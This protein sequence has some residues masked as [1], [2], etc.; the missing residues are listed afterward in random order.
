MTKR[1]KKIQELAGKLKGLIFVGT[2]NLTSTAMG[3]IFWFFIAALM[4]TEEYGEI[5]YV[6][7]IGGIVGSLAL[8]GAPD[9]ITVFS[10]K[11][12]KPQGSYFFITIIAAI[13]SSIILLIFIQN[14]ELSLYVIGYV[15]FTL[16][17][18]DVLGKKKF[19]DYSKYLISQKIIFIVISVCLFYIIGPK[20]IIFGFALSFF[21]YFMRIYFGFKETKIETKIIKSH[22][23]FSLNNYA[24]DLAKAFS[25][26]VDKLIIGPLLGF[27]LLGNYALGIQVLMVFTLLP[28]IMF[29]YI[30]PNEAGGNPSKKMK[31]IAIL[32]AILIGFIGSIAVPSIL[33][34][35]LPKYS[36]ATDVIRIISF[37]VIPNTITLMYRSKFLSQNNSFPLMIAGIIYVIVQVAC[38][39]TLGMIY[40]VNGIASALLIA[41]ISQAIFLFIVDKKKKESLQPNL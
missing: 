2:G 26:H 41:A 34:S 10:A 16:A 36:E 7:S 23:R 8:I 28:S 30:L 31:K 12:E 24:G 22:M 14:I 32:V 1:F 37:A 6:L 19:K 20:G 40:D 33:S 3:A 4:S 25:G 29:T 9:T 18:A 13:V 17:I 39:F 5:S 38:I 21:P 15:I 11:G 27:S 35:V